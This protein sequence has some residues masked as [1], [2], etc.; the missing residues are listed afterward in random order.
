MRMKG[1]SNERQ[2]EFSEAERSIVKP[3]SRGL[4]VEGKLTDQRDREC[5][6]KISRGW[7]T[8]HETY[9]TMDIVNR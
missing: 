2:P 3:I 5:A 8:S 6:N 4:Q 9:P 7:N 1:F